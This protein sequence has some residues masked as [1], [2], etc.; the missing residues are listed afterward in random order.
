MFEL[1]ETPISK[2]REKIDPI[3]FCMMTTRSAD[4]N[5]LSRPM[6]HQAIDEDGTLWFFTSDDSQVAEDL[7]RDSA[8]NIS[9]SNPSDNLYVSLSGDAVLIKDAQKAKQ[10]WNPMVKAWFPTGPQDP[11][12]TLIKFSTYSAEYWDSDT[13]KMLHLFAMAKEVITGHH[14][15][16]KSEHVKLHF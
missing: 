15:K 6:T 9:F 12:L 7:Y 1:I 10:L 13:N 3:Q 11:R 16:P 4:H 2:L 14:P 5:L 8:A